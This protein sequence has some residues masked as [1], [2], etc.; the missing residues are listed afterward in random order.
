MPTC[1][2]R[3]L[4]NRA[5]A[6][7]H[8]AHVAQTITSM[9]QPDVVHL[10]EVE[11]CDALDA[12]IAILEARFAAPAG[13]YRAY[14]VPGR[15]TALGLLCGGGQFALCPPGQA[16]GVTHSDGCFLRR[17]AGQ[18]VGLITKLDPVADVVR[19]DDRAIYP[20]AG[21]RC[22][23][24]PPGAP[25]RLMGCSK[26]YLA[27]LQPAPHLRVVL[28][29]AHLIA[30]PDKKDRCEKV[31]GGCCRCCCCGGFCSRAVVLYV[32]RGAGD[33]AGRRPPRAPPRAPRRRGAGPGRLQRLRRRDC[34]RGGPHRHAH[35]PGKNN[36]HHHRGGGGF[37]RPSVLISPPPRTVSHTPTHA[38]THTHTP[39]SVLREELP[40]LCENIS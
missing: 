2:F 15:D 34:R 30:Y 3:V 1:V 28:A 14:L 32:A 11:G 22:G 9:G 33:R 24:T 16:R 18:Q 12:L 13:A 26:N 8:L 20:V 38:P 31:S 10:T 27:V 7:R 36:H 35:Q 39:P 19:T 21:S 37:S 5:M 4:Q 6:E 25:S 29:G 40:Q 17:F 23:F